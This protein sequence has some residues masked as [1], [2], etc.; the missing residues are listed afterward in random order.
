M[1]G[2]YAAG[3]V[4]ALGVSFVAQA[5]VLARR[6]RAVHDGAAGPTRCRDPQNVARSVCLRGAD[7]PQARRHDHPADDDPDLV[8][9]V[10]PAARR[11]ARPSPAINYS[12]AGHD[13]PRCSQPVLAPIGF[14]W[15]M[16]VALIP[17]MAAR[18]VAV[19]GAGHVY[20]IGGGEAR[21]GAARPRRWPAT[22]RSPPAWRSWPG[23]CSRRNAPRRSAVIRR[24]T[25]G[26][27]WMAVMFFYM[28]AL[29]YA[30]AFATF[31][32]ARAAPAQA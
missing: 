14:N 15:Q 30:A 17:G 5:L 20:A 29:A 18:E 9:V 8:A 4:S 6:G 25:G 28:L 31:Q 24:E 32:I 1:F 26:W 19:G 27:R 3:I 11:P 13:R 7:L 23:T 10:L 22:G 21:R 2:L 12:L 16:T